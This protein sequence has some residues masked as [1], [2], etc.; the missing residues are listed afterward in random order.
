MKKKIVF[1]AM[2]TALL[3]LQA[4]AVFA[5][6]INDDFREA[7]RSEGDLNL[8][9]RLLERGADINSRD[10][11]YHRGSS[12]PYI[13]RGTVLMYCAEAGK[14]DEVVFLIENGARVNLRDDNGATAASIA[15]D[16][17]E[18]EIYNYLKEHG[19]IDFESRQVTNQPS[20][21][22]S[23]TNVYVQPS[24]PAQPA[25]AP[26]TPT[27]QAGTYAASGTNHTMTLIRISDTSGTM[28][29]YVGGGLSV[30]YG[31]YRISNNQLTLSFGPL[32]SNEGLKNKTF[33]YNITSSTSFS[34]NGETWARR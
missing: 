7:V 4:Q 6:D 12:S 24:A 26:A 9:K 14:F 29:Y 32:S 11:W 8:A 23:T 28:D 30:G 20:S 25:P 34:G 27:L 10:S 1:G 15:Y 18:I 19:A 33:I 21:P 16:K 3:V 31:T 17:G 2:L 13:K 5:W 22:S